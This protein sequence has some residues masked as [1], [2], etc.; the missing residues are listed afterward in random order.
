MAGALR[1]RK[2]GYDRIIEVLH[3]TDMPTLL[4]GVACT[5]EHV[6]EPRPRT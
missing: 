1:W 3:A 5:R 6:L 4:S 2:L